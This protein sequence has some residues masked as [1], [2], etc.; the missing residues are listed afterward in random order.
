MPRVYYE[1]ASVPVVDD[2]GDPAT[3]VISTPVV[4]CGP[5]GSPEERRAPTYSVDGAETEE[6]SATEFETKAG[7]H[8]RTTKSREAASH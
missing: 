5:P 4:V 2:Y 6:L 1:T 3:L 7:R 8:W